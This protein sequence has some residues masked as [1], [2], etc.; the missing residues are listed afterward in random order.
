MPRPLPTVVAT[1]SKTMLEVSREPTPLCRD[2][3][4]LFA[5]FVLASRLDMEE[6]R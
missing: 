2:S 3:R 6:S 4:F 5:G 1:V